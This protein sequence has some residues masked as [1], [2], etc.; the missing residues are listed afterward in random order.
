MGQYHKIVNLDKFEYLD[1]FT[2]GSSL[3][4]WEQI[5]NAP[6]TPM[7]LFV[8]LMASNG[9]GGGDL[10]EDTPGADQVIGRWK[11]DRIAVVGDY[12]NPDDLPAEFEASTIYSRCDPDKQVPAL[13]QLASAADDDVDAHYRQKP[14]AAVYRNISHL[15]AP[16]LAAE[17]DMEWG[18][19]NYRPGEMRLRHKPEPEPEPEVIAP[20][21]PAV[22]PKRKRKA[23]TV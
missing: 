2:L 5:A 6:G 22:K 19:C 20:P 3:K 13:V 7:A 4:A 8:L 10:N 23:K 9:R 14:G 11:G 1:P 21:E 16:I 17:L 15:V 18:P 12:A